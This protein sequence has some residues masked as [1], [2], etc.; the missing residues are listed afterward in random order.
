MNVNVSGK[1]NVKVQPVVNMIDVLLLRW[2]KVQPVMDTIRVPLL[3]WMSQAELCTIDELL[4]SLMD[5]V[6]VNV[7]VSTATNT[8]Y[9]LLL[10]GMS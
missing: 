1:L 9:V 7:T 10:H 3:R 5:S 2:M 4:S 8:N 6:V